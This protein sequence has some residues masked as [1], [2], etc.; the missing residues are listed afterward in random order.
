[1][2]NVK[3]NMDLRDNLVLNNHGEE[4]KVK[5][6]YD[7]KKYIAEN[8][9]PMPVNKDGYISLVS[10]VRSIMRQPIQKRSTFQI[11]KLVPLVKDLPFFRERGLKDN[12][13]S[14]TLRLMH[15]KEAE[16]GDLIIEYGTK[17]DEFYV[18]LEGECEV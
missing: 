9:S 8:Y 11:N 6:T 16:Q 12:A 7:I 17:G 2:A 13:I 1:M 10:L 14:D 3:K 5:A 18:L 15:Y 4:F